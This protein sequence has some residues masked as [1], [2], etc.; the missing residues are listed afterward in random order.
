MV[1]RGMG[2]YGAV[3]TQIFEHRG[4]RMPRHQAAAMTLRRPT[5]RVLVLLLAVLM[6]LGGLAQATPVRALLRP[7]T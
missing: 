1:R 3:L 7:W 2:R 4:P 5:P 6:T